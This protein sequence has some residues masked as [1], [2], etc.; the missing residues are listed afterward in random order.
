MGTKKGGAP[1]SASLPALATVGQ[2]GRM[3]QAEVTG[4]SR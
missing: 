2:A 4:L 1:Q 3:A